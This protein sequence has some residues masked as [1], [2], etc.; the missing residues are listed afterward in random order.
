MHSVPDDPISS[1][2][3]SLS[4]ARLMKSLGLQPKKRLGQNFLVCLDVFAEM[5]DRAAVCESDCVLEVGTGLGRTTRMIS[6][7]AGRVVAVEID[8]ELACIAAGRCAERGNVEVLTG[9]V[10]ASKK[11]LGAPVLDAL[12]RGAESGRRLKLVANLPYVVAS[13]LLL[14]ILESPLEFAGAWV[15]VQREVAQ[16][17]MAVPRTKA[18]GALSVFAQLWA[19]VE[20]IAVLPPGR[21]WPP[22]AVDSS[23]VALVRTRSRRARLCSYAVF[24]ALVRA[25]F[26]GRRKL[27]RNSVA[28][29]L[30]PAADEVL[31]A[32][33]LARTTRSDEV[34]LDGIIELANL[35]AKT[36]G[37]V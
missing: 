35:V 37:S 18:Y 19:D 7:R 22:P 36:A 6:E 24:S 1:D 12:R 8:P 16:R 10:L 32:A 11:V 14:D 9:D 20:E 28:G 33:G 30:G 34:P 25:I 2:E 5:L 17:L 26:Q 27:L 13:P 3:A 23:A 31:D 21:F 29:M 15:M 4:P